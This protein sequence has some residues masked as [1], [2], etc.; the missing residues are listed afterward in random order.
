MTKLFI[1]HKKVHFLKDV[2]AAFKGP[3]NVKARM[4]LSIQIMIVRTSPGSAFTSQ[5]RVTY[6]LMIA[7]IPR[8]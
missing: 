6:A 4:K 2:K 5:D 1:R 8:M 3:I 7:T